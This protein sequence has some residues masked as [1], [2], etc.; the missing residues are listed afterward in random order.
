LAIGAV[1]VGGEAGAV[2]DVGCWGGAVKRAAVRC[3]GLRMWVFINLKDALSIVNEIFVGLVNMIKD[4]VLP[5]SYLAALLFIT[6]L[7]SFGCS[8]WLM[9]Y[10][11]IIAALF[12]IGTV[13]SVFV[14]LIAYISRAGSS[15]KGVVSA[16]VW[17]F[18]LLG[19]FV[20]L[21]R[22]LAHLCLG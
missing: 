8:R 17:V 12:S 15:A 20:E 3:L 4:Y 16:V 1:A 11:G 13:C 9:S 21:R 2:G 7:L 22:F 18:I 10:V 14:F 19:Y 5:I 6:A